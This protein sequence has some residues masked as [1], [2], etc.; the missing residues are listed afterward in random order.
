LKPLRLKKVLGLVLQ[1]H[2]LLVA[3][4]LAGEQPKLKQVA[5]MVYPPGVTLHQPVELG[6]AL[7]AFLKQRDFSTRQAVIGLPLKWLVVKKK[8]VPAADE[9][10]VNSMLRLEAEAEF[11]SELKDLV[12]DYAADAS[13]AKR[14]ESRT[15]LLAATPRRHIELV[16]SLCES[17]RVEAEAIMPTALALGTASAPQ[18]G[19][20][21]LVLSVAASGSE[22]SASGSGSLMRHLRPPTPPTAFF[23]EL[24]RVVSG[25]PGSDREMVLWDQSGLQA[26]DLGN[27]LRMPVKVGELASLGVETNGSLVN[28]EGSRFGGAVALALVGIAQTPPAVDFLH[29]RLAPPSEHRI[30]IWAWYAAGGLLAVIIGAIIA[31]HNLDLQQ[32]NVNELQ[33][34]LDAMKSDVTEA[35]KFVSKVTV[36]RYW[37]N[38]S[39]ARYL[40]CLRDLDSVIPEDGNTYATSLDI[41]APTPALASAGLA[42]TGTSISAQAKLPDMRT[43]MVNL[44]GRTPSFDNVTALVERMRRMPG[45]FTDIKIGPSTKVPRTNEILF[46]VTFTYVPPP[47]SQAAQPAGAEQGAGTSDES[48]GGSGDSRQSGSVRSMPGT[49]APAAANGAAQPSGS[50]A[51]TIPLTMEPRTTQPAPSGANP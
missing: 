29:S 35:E 40:A 12:Y 19:R 1:E 28:G 7:G 51:A 33:G 21:L 13:G 26:A 25:Y 18:P 42:P 20:N 9:A 46:S 15:V 48:E 38:E 43:L 36:A 5:E 6:K 23:S 45:A 22:L 16:E 31:Y 11:S 2:S 50:R 34:Q 8:E 4:V 49:S 47:V 27:Q 44:Q 10:T 37:H 14:R 32:Q 41:K 39:D 17:A 30:P 24:R 3:E